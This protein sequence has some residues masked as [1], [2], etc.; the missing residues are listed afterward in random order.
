MDKMSQ[1]PFC[2]SG[3]RASP[4][5]SE[6]GLRHFVHQ[7]LSCNVLSKPKVCPVHFRKPA[8]PLL[9]IACLSYAKELFFFLFRTTI[10]KLLNIL[11]P[12]DIL[13][14]YY[15]LGVFKGRMNIIRMLHTFLSLSV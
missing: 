7:R 2:P 12:P 4:L 3:P 1:A 13:I 14:D 11:F 15:C 10:L 9:E 6:G 8:A 5:M